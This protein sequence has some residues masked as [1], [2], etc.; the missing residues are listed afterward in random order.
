MIRPRLLTT[1]SYGA[2]MA[3][4]IGLNMLPVFLTTLSV[5]YGGETG[6]TKEQLGRLGAIM[7]A[8]LV[9]G[10]FI[11]GPLADRLGAKPF[12]L[13]GNGLIVLSLLAMAFAPNYATLAVALGFL[14]LG[15]GILDMVLSPV[16]SA[17]NPERRASAMNW[18]HS[19]YCVGAALTI[20]AG[21]VVL[22]AGG[23]WRVACLVLLPLPALLI[24]FFAPLKFPQMAHEERR[25]GLGSLMGQTWFRLA[26]VA[27]FLGGAT[28]LGMAQWLP[29]YAETSLG[30]APWVGGMG[31]LL[32]SLAM[33]F[34]RMAVGA[35]GTRLDPFHT[36]AW[37][38]GL[39]VL[40]FL[41]ASFIPHPMTALVCCIAAGFT[42]SCL[43]PTVLAVTADHYPNGGATMFGV[44]S[45]FGNAGGIFMP[46]VVGWVAD[47]S[48]LHWGLAISALAPLGMLPIILVM[49]KAR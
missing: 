45:A 48:N 3:L 38:C 17:L 4:S 29:A 23:G 44:L 34:G 15:S 16:V 14:G 28:E 1:L 30:F 20:L 9:G 25:M 47:L 7:F 26:L 49:R 37:G 42:G 32:F 43:W 36:M 8:G 39:S 19:F 13:L 33:A 6:L 22:K 18:L 40:L 35:A 21:T 41:G 12:V 31:L 5:T 24:V 10:I 46:W 2:M 11:T 27:L